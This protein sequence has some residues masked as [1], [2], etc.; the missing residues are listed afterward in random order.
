M[1]ILATMFVT[2]CNFYCSEAWVEAFFLLLHHPKIAKEKKQSFFFRL[3]NFQ[4]YFSIAC[5]EQ[6]R[7]LIL[8]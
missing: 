5:A 7:F 1:S 2:L 6:Q 4:Q 8:K 3:I